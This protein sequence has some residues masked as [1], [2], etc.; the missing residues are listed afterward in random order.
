MVNLL[1]TQPP[2]QRLLSQCTIVNVTCNIGLV[3]VLAGTVVK[4]QATK[5][6]T[7]NN[8]TERISKY[9]LNLSIIATITGFSTE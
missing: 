9:I 6:K 7:T 5:D 1:T 3:V 2:L 8:V 4:I